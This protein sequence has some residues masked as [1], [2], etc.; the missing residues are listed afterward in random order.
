M[1]LLKKTIPKLIQEISKL[2]ISGKKDD[3]K[4]IIEEN[5]IGEDDSKKLPFLIIEN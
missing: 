3:P 5:K 4:P 1:N 2:E